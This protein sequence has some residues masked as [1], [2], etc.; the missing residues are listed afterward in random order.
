MNNRSG[1]FSQTSSAAILPSSLAGTWYPADAENLRT[2][3][4]EAQAE[5]PA[6]SEEAA[7]PN[8]LLLPHA[9]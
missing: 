3:I 4:F 6:P 9:G 8:L 7:T 5:Q 1:T 2:V